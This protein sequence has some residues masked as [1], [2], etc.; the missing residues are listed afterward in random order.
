VAAGNIRVKQARD[1]NLFPAL[2]GIKGQ[3]LYVI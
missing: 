1:F 2:Q 3:G